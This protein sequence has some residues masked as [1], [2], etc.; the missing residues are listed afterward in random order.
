MDRIDLEDLGIER[1]ELGFGFA[2]LEPGMCEIVGDELELDLEVRLVRVVQ[3]QLDFEIWIVRCHGDMNTRLRCA[4]KFLSC[5]NRARDRISARRMRNVLGN[6]VWLACIAAC[7]HS[8]P[9]TPSAKVKLAVM[10]AESPDFPKAA[11]AATESLAG[12][13]VQGVDETEVRKVSID[14]VQ[15]QIE[16]LDPTP[17]CYSAA[18]K[19]IS[20]DE[21]LF[22]KISGAKKQIDVTVTLFDVD[23]SKVKHEAHDS[24]ASEDLAIAGIPKLVA[25]A[26]KR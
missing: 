26:T 22:A 4:G 25:E 21:L 18:G 19:A 13:N 14:V 20:A 3:L 15:L 23:R 7:K 16:C 11:K 8:A 17:A 9:T 6:L 24:F 1:R 2:K 12:A 10:P 5:Q